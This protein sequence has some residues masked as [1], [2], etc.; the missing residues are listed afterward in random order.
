[1]ASKGGS[2][3]ELDL[4]R[5]PVREDGM[6]AYEIMLSE[7]QERM[8]MVLKPGREDEAKAI[9]EK[10]DLDFAIIGRLTDGGRMVIHKGGER[11]CDL[12]IDPLAE[13]APEYDRPWEPTPARDAVDPVDVPERDTEESL[14]TLL[15]CPDL[16]SRQW[17]WEQYDHMV[18]TDTVQRPGGDAGVVR[19]D[20]PRTGGKTKGLAVTV[21]CTPRYVL[22]D[23][24]QGGRQAVAE[25]YR[26]LTAVGAE[27]LAVTDNMNFGNPEKPLVMGQFVGSCQGMGEAC[28]ALAY[29]VVSGNVSLYNET[30][31]TAILPTPAIGG[32]GLIDDLSAM[33]TIAFKASDEAIVLI[34]ET[35]GHLGQS[36]YLREVAGRED[37]PPPPVDLDGERAHG[38]LVRRLIRARQVTACH[39][40]SDGGLL[41]ALAEMAMAGELGC[42]IELPTD[43]PRHAWLFGEDQG[44]YLV[45]ALSAGPI[46]EAAHAAGVPA[47][48]LGRTGG[49]ALKLGDGPAISVERVRDAHARWLPGYMARPD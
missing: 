27:P 38:D 32:L 7:S 28:R 21:D 4:D 16:C 19:V 34:G 43:V 17:V 26:N 24:V 33:A 5:V 10:W 22:A 15:A 20:G 14:L 45:T 44:R 29:P 18:G 8:L 46:L 12:P 41:V 30:G 25:S 9:F 47:R 6:S 37:G 23:P 36:L 39:D 42:T 11:V 40:V 13:N 31:E 1:M 48:V 35:R 3:V 2:G 49:S